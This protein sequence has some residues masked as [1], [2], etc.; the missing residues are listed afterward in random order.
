MSETDKYD[1]P[2]MYSTFVAIFTKAVEADSSTYFLSF[3]WEHPTLGGYVID[4]AYSLW[5]THYDKWDTVEAFAINYVKTVE[6]HD[7]DGLSKR[8]TW[9]KH[10]EMVRGLLIGG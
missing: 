8:R 6:L 4:H 3:R 10:G 2:V 9:H 1:K 7:W 5:Q